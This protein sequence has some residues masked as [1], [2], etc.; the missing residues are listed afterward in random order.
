[1]PT[2]TDTV[3]QHCSVTHSGCQS[4]LPSVVLGWYLA[5]STSE[6]I[7]LTKEQRGAIADHK[8]DV[9]DARFV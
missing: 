5:C 1:M 9:V 3:T 6:V 4:V 8:V 7:T 2:C